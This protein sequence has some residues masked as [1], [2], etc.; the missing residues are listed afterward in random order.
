MIGKAVITVS[1]CSVALSIHQNKGGLEMLHIALCP[2]SCPLPRRQTTTY[3]AKSCLTASHDI[4]ILLQRP[5][6]AGIAGPR[7]AEDPVPVATSP[8]ETENTV[9]R[10]GRAGPCFPL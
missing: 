3:P 1:V 6:A 8:G 2:P 9:F 10:R 7:V 4:G 5:E